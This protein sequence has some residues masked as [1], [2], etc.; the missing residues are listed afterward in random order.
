MPIKI[1]PSV[2]RKLGG[3]ALG[4]TTS[5]EKQMASRQNGKKGGRPRKILSE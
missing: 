1:T 2:L 4:K 5:M 3:F